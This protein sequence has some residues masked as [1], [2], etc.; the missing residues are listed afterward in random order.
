[1]WRA[2][3]VRKP[4]DPLGMKFRSMVEKVIIDNREMVPDASDKLNCS[5]LRIEANWL[6][7]PSR[8]T[9]YWA[10]F[11]VDPRPSETLR[12][13]DDSQ[14]LFAEMKNSRFIPALCLAVRPSLTGHC[15]IVVTRS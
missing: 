5:P 8:D 2:I 4:P 7:P 13:R 3:W 15:P 1:M 9:L 14:E 11:G 10:V 6:L 12:K